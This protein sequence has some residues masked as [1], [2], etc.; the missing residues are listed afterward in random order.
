MT[1]IVTRVIDCWVICK[2]N[3]HIKYLIMKRAEDLLYDGIYHC[4]HG[5]INV[6]EKAWETAVREL[7]E[8]TG[9]KPTQLWTADITSSFYEAPEDR[10][11]LV[12]VFVA[13]VDTQEINLSKEHDTFEWLTFSEARHRVTWNNHKLAIEGINRMFSSEFPHKKWLEVKI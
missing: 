11:N 13:L 4:V 10:F 3:D 7:Y 12:P 6:G 1:E 2:E 9:L 8:E 5:K